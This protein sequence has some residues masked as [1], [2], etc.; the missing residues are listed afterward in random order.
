MTKQICDIKRSHDLPRLFGQATDVI[1]LEFFKECCQ[2]SIYSS[3]KQP[4]DFISKLF[5]NFSGKYIFFSMMKLK[6]RKKFHPNIRSVNENHKQPFS[7]LLLLTLPRT[8]A[9]FSPLPF[10]LPNLHPSNTASCL[11]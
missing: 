10:R 2:C 11:I 4:K 1:L 6:R 3:G 7:F 9:F 5:C 8:C